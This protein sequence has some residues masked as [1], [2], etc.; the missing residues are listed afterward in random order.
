[1]PTPGST[2]P[3]PRSPTVPCQPVRRNA[4]RPVI[5]LVCSRKNKDFFFFTTMAAPDPSERGVLR[6][7]DSCRRLANP[8]NAAGIAKLNSL[9]TP[10]TLDSTRRLSDQERSPDQRQTSLVRPLQPAAFHR[11]RTRIERQPVAFEHSAMPR[12]S[13]T[14]VGVLH[15]HPESE[16]LNEFRFQYLR[17]D[18]PSVAYSTGPERFCARAASL[19]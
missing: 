3:R 4:G 1:M 15:Q 13:L 10:Y 9:L 19:R 8:A 18:E 7:A 11:P 6:H 17:D 14:A 2:T 12:F 5:I 16:L